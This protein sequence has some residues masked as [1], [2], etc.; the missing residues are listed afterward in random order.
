MQQL[1]VEYWKVVCFARKNIISGRVVLIEASQFAHRSFKNYHERIVQRLPDYRNPSLHG[2]R[3]VKVFARDGDL[4]AGQANDDHC[5]TL[6][7]PVWIHQPLIRH[8][9]K[10]ET[11]NR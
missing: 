10:P 3:R 7:G 6:S 5:A 2:N 11:I 8:V 4:S 1:A 9:L